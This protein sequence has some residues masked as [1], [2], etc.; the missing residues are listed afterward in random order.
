MKARAATSTG[1]DLIVLKGKLIREEFNKGG[2]K[3]RSARS[4]GHSIRNLGAYAHGRE[5]GDKVNLNRPLGGSGNG[6]AGLIS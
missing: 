4:S 5:A 1:T 2:I 3:L 6:N